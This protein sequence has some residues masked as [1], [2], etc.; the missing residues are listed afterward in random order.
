MSHRLTTFLAI[1]LGWATLAGTAIAITG[2]ALDSITGLAVV[3]V[4]YMPSPLVAALIVER[5]FVGARFRLPARRLRGVAVFLL[6]PVLAIAAFVLLY[7][8]AVYIGGNLLGLDALGTLATTS[9]EVVAGAARLVGQTAV[10]AAGPPPPLLVL[11]LAGLW[12]AVVAGWTV[13]GLVAMGEEYGWRGLMWDELRGRG[14]VRANV[15]IGVAWGLWHAPLILQGYN[16]PGRPVVGV[17]AMMVF[18]TGMSF[19]LTGLRELT[20]S[21]LPVA[22]AHGAFNAVAALLLLLTA[23][24]DPLSTGPLGA[25]GGVLLLGLGAGMWSLARRRTVAAGR[26]ADRASSS[27]DLRA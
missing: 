21:L 7:L 16:Y 14:V 18:C 11:V 4:L 19:V 15:A 6:S 1:A 3:A 24:A 12:G 8:A 23:G 2:I 20:G 13:N 22:A 26:A 9:E 17:L 25:L 5:R 10:D 27:R